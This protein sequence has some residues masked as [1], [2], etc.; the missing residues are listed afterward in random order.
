MNRSDCF[1]AIDL[2]TNSCRLLIA[3]AK[4]RYLFSESYSVKMGEGMYAH[5]RFTPEA[6]ARGVECFYKMKQIMDRFHIVKNRAIATASCRMAQNAPEFIDAV[7]KESLIRLE[8]VDGYEEA[9][10]NLKGAIEHVQGK[11]EYVVL[12]DLGGGSTEITLATNTQTPKILY[13]I[14]IPWGARNASEAFDLVEYDAV[15][16]KKLHD[17]IAA[18]TQSFVEASN[19]ANIRDKVC[20]VATSSTPLRFVSMIEKFGQYDRD[21][22]DGHV[23]SCKDIDAQIE[24]VYKLTRA[25]MMENLYIGQK[26]SSIF[27]AACVIFKTIYD[28]LGAKEITASLKSAKDGIISELIDQYNFE[29][30]KENNGKINQ[31]SQRNSR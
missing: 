2:G 26:R 8:V 22:S 15:K 25:E 28:T 6:F 4:K 3:D 18:K 20:F 14:S 9:R 10:L 5:M 16:A 12:Y 31:I 1:A 17:E 24:G 19:L 13:T 30:H 7:Y 21:K 23:I 29:H 27:T 11:S